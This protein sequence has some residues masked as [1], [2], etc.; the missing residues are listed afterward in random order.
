ML[1]FK[2]ESVTDEQKLDRSNW[3][4]QPH[5]KRAATEAKACWQHASEEL[6]AACRKSTDPEV[7]GAYARL[8]ALAEIGRVLNG[9][10]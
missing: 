2:V 10:D 7:R 6:M 1:V 8:M 5:T 4:D 3:L 9:S